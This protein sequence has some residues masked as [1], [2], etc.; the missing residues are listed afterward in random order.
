MAIGGTHIVTSTR[1]PAPD[2]STP[3][4]RAS[5]TPQRLGSTPP[6]E[7]RVRCPRLSHR[8]GRAL[9]WNY[10]RCRLL[11]LPGCGEAPTFVAPRCVGMARQVR[12]VSTG[13]RPGRFSGCR[14]WCSTRDARVVT[15]GVATMNGGIDV[16]RTDHTCISIPLSTNAT[17][18]RFHTRSTSTSSTRRMH[19]T[20]PHKRTHVTASSAER[21]KSPQS[22]GRQSLETGC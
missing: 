1:P 15:V 20:H 13:V 10:R 17:S 14:R 2:T 5:C 22:H 16:T 8:R 9:A 19:K 18:T 12:C 21:F 7:L 3:L 11:R 4:R 6:S